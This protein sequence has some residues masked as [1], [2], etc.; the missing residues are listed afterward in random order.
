MERKRN[1]IR[2]NG[3]TAL[4]VNILVCTENEY[5]KSVAEAV[6]KSLEDLGFGVSIT[7]KKTLEDFKKALNEGHYSL[8]IGETQ[9]SYDY[10]LQE[11]FKNSGQLSYGISEDFFA[12]YENYRNGTDSFMTFIEAFETEVPFVP[13]FY[14]RSIV[15]VNPNITGINTEDIYSSACLWQLQD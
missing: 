7:E 5:K 11:F 8:Y 12:Q 1:R 6:K 10:N 14:R 4:R 2:T 13:L 3:V 15:S 9:L